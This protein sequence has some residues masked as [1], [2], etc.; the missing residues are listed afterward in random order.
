MNRMAAYRGQPLLVLVFLLGAWVIARMLLWQTPFTGAPFVHPFKRVAS[1]ELP[2]APRTTEPA[3]PGAPWQVG[4]AVL[5]PR[6]PEVQGNWAVAP[7]TV[8][9]P[10]VATPLSLPVEPDRRA[11]AAALTPPP[12]REPAAAPFTPLL[13]TTGRTATDRWSADAWL[14]LREDTTTPVTSGRGSY[15]QSQAGMVVRYRLAPTSGHR[16][17]AYYRATQALA[18]ARETEAALGL[19][20]RPVPG[21]PVIAAAELRLTRVDGNS[22]FRPAAFAVTEL[23]PFDLAAGFTGEAYFQA[24]YVGGDFETAFVDGQARAERKLVELGDAELHAGGGVWGGAQEGATRL[25]VGPSATL[26]LEIGG[27]P[28]RVSLDWRLRVAGEAEPQSGP[29]LTISAGF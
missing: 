26:R 23:P 22:S 1:V 18:G 9:E 21:L 10:P 20:A 15:G 14:L 11:T 24:G 28:S 25:D 13:A 2:P 17:V 6:V 16:P 4:S 5:Q 8:S 7:F 29:A 3:Q 27:T 19:A 12:D